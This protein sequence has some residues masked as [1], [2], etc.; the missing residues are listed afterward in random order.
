VQGELL[1]T[2]VYGPPKVDVGEQ[3]KK[4]QRKKKMQG[5][6][7]DEKKFI[8]FFGHLFSG[9]FASQFRLQTA[10]KEG[11]SWIALQAVPPHQ[12]ERGSDGCSIFTHRG[13]IQRLL[14]WG[15]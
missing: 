11:W 10:L 9:I 13:G 2:T 3:E 8:R 4:Q 1:S 7:T 6:K 5:N 12:K 14:F 15:E